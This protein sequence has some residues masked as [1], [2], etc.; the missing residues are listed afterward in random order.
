MYRSHEGT[1]RWRL[2]HWLLSCCGLVKAARFGALT[3]QN[4]TKKAAMVLEN[5]VP[6]ANLAE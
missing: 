5:D 3:A 2:R 1:C 4:P 6:S